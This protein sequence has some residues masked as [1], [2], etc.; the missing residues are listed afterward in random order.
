MMTQTPTPKAR[1]HPVHPFY[2]HT[3]LEKD[4]YWPSIIL[5]KVP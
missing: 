2:T 3:R 5:Q 1:P 4:L